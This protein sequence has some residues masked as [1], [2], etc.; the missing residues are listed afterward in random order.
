MVR[1]NEAVED[2]MPVVGF[3]AE[4]PAIAVVFFPVFGF[5]AKPL[6][7]SV[8]GHY[9]LMMINLRDLPTPTRNRLADGDIC[10]MHQHTP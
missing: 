2:E 10:R 7:I 9:Y 3:V 5:C 6:F 8:T 4:V 1:E